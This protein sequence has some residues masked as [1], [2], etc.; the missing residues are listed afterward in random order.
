MRRFAIGQRVRVIGSAFTTSRRSEIAELYTSR[1][2]RP[3]YWLQDGGL[4]DD[5]ELEDDELF[6]SQNK[7]ANNE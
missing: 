6:P 1:D 2:G 7:G 3:C 4:L 5:R